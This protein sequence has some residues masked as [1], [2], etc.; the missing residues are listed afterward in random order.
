MSGE[1]AEKDLRFWYISQGRI[2]SS[3]ESNTTCMHC[4]WS[5]PPQRY[6]IKYI[7]HAL[8]ALHRRKVTPFSVKSAQSPGNLAKTLVKSYE[9]KFDYYLVARVSRMNL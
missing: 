9:Q 8:S 4:H 3:G 2:R 6:R 5:P 1:S 7:S